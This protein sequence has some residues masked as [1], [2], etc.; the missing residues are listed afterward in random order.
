MQAQGIGRAQSPEHRAF[1]RAVRE[2]RVRRALSQEALGERG[3]LHRNYVGAIERGEV[4]PT[5][6]TLMKLASG[7][8]V[9]L[10]ELLEV[11]ERHAREGG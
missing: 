8:N 2:T 6:K 1:G 7:L 11:A 4:N 5:F 10:G 3:G 9:P